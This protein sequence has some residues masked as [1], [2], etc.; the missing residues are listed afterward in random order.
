MKQKDFKHV[1]QVKKQGRNKTFCE[2]CLRPN[3]TVD[4]GYTSCCNERAVSYEEAICEAARYD[5]QE[6]LGAKFEVS[7]SLH[8]YDKYHTAF[9]VKLPNK[10]V[11]FILYT[12]ANLEHMIK[13]VKQNTKGLRREV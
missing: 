2:C 12:S 6:Y 11:E 10:G 4:D 9:I 5:V 8:S 13:Q 7:T 3:P 1:K